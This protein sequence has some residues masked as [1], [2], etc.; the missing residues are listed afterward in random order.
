VAVST[1]SP[2]RYRTGATGIAGNV[3]YKDIWQIVKRDASGTQTSIGPVIDEGL[4][5]CPK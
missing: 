1:G 2:H 3:A 4:G 5:L